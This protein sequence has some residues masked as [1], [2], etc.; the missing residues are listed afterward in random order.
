MPSSQS[1]DSIPDFPYRSSSSSSVGSPTTG[2]GIYLKRFTQTTV[3]NSL[4]SGFRFKVVAHDGNEM[5]NSI[6]RYQREAL[7][8]RD[9]TYRLVFDGVCSPP[10]IEEFAENEPAVGVFPEFCRL[11]YVD[12]VFRSQAVAEEAWTILVEEVANLVVT[13]NKMDEV[14]EEADVKIGNPPTV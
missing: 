14:R 9:G 8:A 13:L 6:F 2:R 5:T 7:N 10:D 1:S 12:L 3:N 4:I 11:D